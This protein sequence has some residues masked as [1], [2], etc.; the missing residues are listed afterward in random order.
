MTNMLLAEEDQD[1]LAGSILETIRM[2]KQPNHE[3][4]NAPPIK[5]LAYIP[6]PQPSAAR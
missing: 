1:N 2:P 4:K 3:Q 6:W 5:A